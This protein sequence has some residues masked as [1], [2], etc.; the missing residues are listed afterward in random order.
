[1]LPTPQHNID[2][3]TN[4]QDAAKRWVKYEVA[5]GSQVGMAVFSDVQP[6]QNPV[7]ANLT[8][9]DEESREMLLTKIDQMQFKG[10]VGAIL[11]EILPYLYICRPV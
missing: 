6:T 1:M 5:E 10:Q 9:V 11:Q 4:L 3:A 7:L 2:R 8:T